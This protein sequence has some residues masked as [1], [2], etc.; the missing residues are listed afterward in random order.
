MYDRMQ[1]P[2]V[3]RLF[4]TGQVAKYALLPGLFP[5][6]RR[7]SDAFTGFFFMFTQIL[8]TAG[9]IDP[10]HPCLRYENRRDYPFSY[11]LGLAWMNVK[12]DKKNA[13]QVGIFVAVILALLLLAGMFFSLLGKLFVN[14]NKAH[15]QFFGEPNDPE[16]TANTDWA[17]RFLDRIFGD[18]NSTGVDFWTHPGGGSLAATGAQ[19]PWF[20]AIFT[21]MMEHYSMALLFIAA[22]MILYLLVITIAEAARTGEPFGSR[23]DSVWAP[24][25]LAMAIG[26]LVPV[27]G[28][29]YNAAQ[30]IVFQASEWGSNLATNVWNAGLANLQ[31]E[32]F[33]SIP[34]YDQKARF[35]HDMLLI[36]LCAY[37]LT[38]PEGVFVANGNYDVKSLVYYATG[39]GKMSINVGPDSDKSYC[40]QLTVPMPMMAVPTK[41]IP[42][43]GTTPQRYITVPNLDDPA[44]P[45]SQYY[46]L[47]PKDMSAQAMAVLNRMI[48]YNLYTLAMFMPNNSYLNVM[49]LV[50]KSLSQGSGSMTLPE[51]APSMRDV[52]PTSAPAS[53]TVVWHDTVNTIV[54]LHKDNAQPV[55]NYVNV[56]NIASWVDS[57]EKGMGY[58]TCLNTPGAP[59][60]VAYCGIDITPFNKWLVDGLKKDSK[61]GW[62]TAGVFYLRLSN[63]FA[64]LQR[65][66]DGPQV[67][68]LPK[69]YTKFYAVPGFSAIPNSFLTFVCSSKIIKF[70]TFGA[71]NDACDRMEA[72][73]GLTTILRQASGDFVQGPIGDATLYT[74]LGGTQWADDLAQPDPDSPTNVGT[75]SVFGSVSSAL[76]SAVKIN[77]GDINPLG[78]VIRWGNS[79]MEIAAIAYLIG[80]VVGVLVPAIGDLGLTLGHSFMIP[81]FILAYFIPMQPFLYFMFA[82]IE[83]MISVLEAVIGMPLWALSFISLEGDFL[84]KGMNGVKMIFELVLRPTIIVF[85]LLASVLIFT[86]S[87][88]FV[89]DS[90][91]LFLG[92]YNNATSGSMGP[93]AGAIGGFAMMLIYMFLIYSLATSCFKLI[94]A[95]PNEFGRWLELPRGFGADIKTG[96]SSLSGVIA[97]G[98][99]LKLADAAAK[100]PG[101]IAQQVK[102]SRAAAK[103]EEKQDQISNQLNALLMGGGRGGGGGGSSG[104]TPPGGG[105]GPPS[106][107]PPGMGGGGLPPAPR[108][109]GGGSPYGGGYTS[110]TTMPGGGS[111]PPGGGSGG[112]PPGPRPPGSTTSSGSGAPPGP[113]PPGGGSGGGG[114]GTTGSGGGG[115]YS[116]FSSSSTSSSGMGSWSYTTSGSGSAYE[117]KGSKKND[118]ELEDEEK[119]LQRERDRNKGRDEGP[120]RGS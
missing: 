95:I 97:G 83:W 15:A 114:G 11:V 66:S 118:Q 32:K 67:K 69:N 14:V 119:R 62:T 16:W 56:T 57:Y 38:H 75:D 12:F 19:N 5:R 43:P 120:E 30:L 47:A 23:F 110:T 7:L 46:Q 65:A 86:A 29:G 1:E 36:N 31:D 25:R 8:G 115:I 68:K 59:K 72:A 42:V 2:P 41:N 101:G 4:T 102:S 52:V 106:G 90:F 20:T 112:P 79:L 107:G 113:T 88:Q 116:G 99:A 18:A 76:V 21:G 74:K 111:P 37:S 45:E 61:F 49:S 80:I 63:G 53:D 44:I 94:D 27:S 78:Q 28:Q 9:L 26:L 60:D 35:M 10:N 73:I 84:G 103:Q 64:L 50:G 81:G 108:P 109:P 22:M 100:T 92:A 17:Y 13:P 91:S 33:V 98:A 24:I 104:G 6:L 77:N 87:I 58:K 85:S 34:H 55:R 82:V 51:P 71:F 89:N 70:F 96:V 54:Q 105:G 93:L 117:P 40:G 3:R 48:G 39:S